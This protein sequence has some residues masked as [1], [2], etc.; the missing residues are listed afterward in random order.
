MKNSNGRLET[1]FQFHTHT[2][3]SLLDGFSTPEEYLKKCTELGISGFGITEHGNMYS[4]P[5]FEKEK[6]NYPD[7]KMVY[8]IEFY[9]AFDSK[10]KDEKNKYFH[11]VCLAKNEN[12]RLAI[13]KLVTESYRE[14]NF[15]YKPR[16]DLDMLKEYAD[17]L[18]ISSACLGSK[19]AKEQDYDKCVEYIQ[20]YKSIFKHFYLEMQ[21]HKSASQVEYNKKILSLAKDTN[22]P[23]VITT[24]AHASSEKELYYQSYHVKIAKDM[25]TASEIYEGCYLQDIDTIYETMIPQV[26][27]ENVTTAL[28]TSLDI[29]DTI[30]DV[31]IPFS[32]PNLPELELGELTPEERLEQLAYEGLVLRKIEDRF[33]DRIDEYTKRLEVEMSVIKD[34]GFSSYFLIVWDFLNYAKCKNMPV[35]DARGSAGG[36]LVLY[37]IGVTNIDPIKYGLI[38][39]RFLNKE[40]INYPDIDADFADQQAIISYL[41][42]KYGEKKVCRVLNFSYITPKVAIKDVGDI[43]GVPYKIRDEI[44][45]LF[46]TTNFDADYNENEIKLIKYI[47]ENPEYETWFDIARNLSGKIRQTSIHACAVGILNSEVTEIMPVQ[48]GGKGEKIIQCDMKL[49]EKMG[50]VKFDILGVKTLKVVFDTLNSIGKDMSY[51]DLDNED[52]INNKKAYQIIRDGNTDGL[53]QIESYGMRDLFQ[54][55]NAT[56]INELSDGISLYRPDAMGYIPDYLQVKS[57]EKD[58]EY[59]HKDMRSILSATHGSLIYQEQVLEIIRTFGG[60]TYGGADIVRRAIGKKNKEDVEREAEK[61]RQ[62]IL[63]NGYEHDVSE[64]IANYLA[65]AGNYSFN[66]SHGVGYATLVYKTAFLKANHTIEYMTALLNSEVGNFESINKY[67]LNCRQMKIEVLP[68][69]INKSEEFFT[70]SDGKILFGISMIKGVGSSSADK[71]IEERNNEKFKSFDDFT[72]RCKIDKG[73]MVALIKSGIFGKDKLGLLKKYCDSIFQKRY[74]SPLKTTSGY[75]ISRLADELNIYT[76]DKKERLRLFNIFKEKQ[77]EESQALKLKKHRGTFL[78]KYMRNRAKWEFETLSIYLTHNPLEEGLKHVYDFNE[79][80]ISDKVTAI[81][82]V[83]SIQKKNGKNGQ[84]AFIDFYNGVKNIELIFWGRAW[85]K[86]NTKIKKGMDLAV[87][88][89]KEDDNKIIVNQVK[90]YKAWCSEK[91]V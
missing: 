66:K 72:S 22:T 79:Y 40:R 25:D 41:E 86:Y 61:L 74:F 54:K 10:I 46:P 8:G 85:S 27:E 44:S 33:P 31:S 62:E 2:Q 50:I 13:N 24:D 59:I 55:I 88:G 35:S 87:I 71:I 91:G 81:G 23:F 6:Q 56:N 21:S 73:S 26:G 42:D 28:Q 65:D 47:D 52:F 1:C 38:F 78:E 53:F 49:V 5:Y 11:L 20:E 58:A 14:E 43:F 83:V 17:D 69:S 32:E 57:G 7:V 67:I 16:I 68:P 76:K 89:I 70:I 29:L 80:D 84:F 19:I 45:K 15:Y 30:D 51:L 82:T 37:L 90:P 18:I 3:Y 77:F 39:E 9:E 12:G 63:D 60:R 36:S 48:I 4:A 75:T 34:T 64:Y